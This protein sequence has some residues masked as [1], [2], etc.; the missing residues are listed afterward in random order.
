MGRLTSDP[1]TLEV[2]HNA[3]LMSAMEMKGVAVRTAYSPLWK[4]VLINWL[5]FLF[6]AFVVCWSRYR[7]EVV[8]REVEEAQAMED[9]A[10]PRSAR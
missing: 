8:K 9:L 4:E 7:L 6:F 3:L 2:V 1:I 10:L 5:A